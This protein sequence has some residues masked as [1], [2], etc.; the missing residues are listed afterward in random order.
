MNAAR[1]IQPWTEHELEG[2]SVRELRVIAVDA[3]YRWELKK[4]EL[5]KYILDYQPRRAEKP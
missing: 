5:I 4:C 1:E 3:R 2:K